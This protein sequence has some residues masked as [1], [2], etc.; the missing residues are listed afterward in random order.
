MALLQGDMR[1][2][3]TTR[4]KLLSGQAPDLQYLDDV[5]HNKEGAQLLKLLL[6]VECR[7]E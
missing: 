3:K 2:G 5:Q 7:L 1:T 4:A 6:L